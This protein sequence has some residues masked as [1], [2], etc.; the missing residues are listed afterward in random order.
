MAKHLEFG[1]HGEALAEEYLRERGFK[2][3][4]RR[5]RCRHGELDLVAKEKSAWVFVEVKTRANARRGLAAEAITPRK[6]G[7]LRQAIREY[8]YLHRL[9]RETL[10]GDVVTIDFR[11]DGLPEI[12]HSPAAFNVE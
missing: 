6:I 7:H 11:P 9:E 8:V 3:V 4:A 1:E 12:R 2:I 5:V 10:R